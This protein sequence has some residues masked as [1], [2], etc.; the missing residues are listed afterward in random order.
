MVPGDNTMMA[1]LAFQV[2]S[3]L[4]FIGLAADF[5]VRTRRRVRSMGVAA[6]LD[7][8]PAVVRI[9]HSF[10]CKACLVARTISTLAILGRSAFRLAELSGGWT[11]PLMAKQTLFYVME[12]AMISVA[13][14]MLNVFHPAVCFKEM[15]DGPAKKRQGAA[16]DMSWRSPTSALTSLEDLVGTSSPPYG[17]PFGGFQL[18]YKK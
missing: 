1:G 2:A 11:G 13:C 17:Q 3:I 4:V 6:A 10:M 15:M 12:S 8:N 5:A 16:Q 18:V 9:R 14:L 7:Q